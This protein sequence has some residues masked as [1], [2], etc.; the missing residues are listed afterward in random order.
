MPAIASWSYSRLSDFES[1]KF[2]AYLKYVER[3]PEP[4]RPLPPGKTEHANDRGTRI[5]ENAELFVRGDE[6]EL[7]PEL[8]KFEPEFHHLRALYA[9]GQVSLE[10]EWGYDEDWTPCD[11]RT[12]WLRVKIDSMTFLSPY[13]AVVVDYKT[14]KKFGN[15]IKHGE[16]TRLYQVAAFLRFPELEIVHTEL[17]YT[18]QDDI[19]PATF[20]RDQGVRF[21]ANFDRRGRAITTAKD[22]PP[23][24]NIFSCQWC[25][26]GP[27]GT[28]HCKVGIRK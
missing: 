5:H 6:V 8:R 1:C 9:V 11:W 14:G 15:E 16:Q 26:Y 28:G 4:E 13:E 2:R 17:W 7:T 3:I 21:R 10:G 19:T 23:N 25:P 12:A 22:F 24:P 20:T 18:D 27:W